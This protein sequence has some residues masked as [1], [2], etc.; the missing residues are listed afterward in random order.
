MRL[1]HKILPNY[2]PFQTNM[3]MDSQPFESMYLLQVASSF[4]HPRLSRLSNGRRFVVSML[5]ASLGGST[6]AWQLLNH[7]RCIRPVVNNGTIS[8]GERGK[9]PY[10]DNTT[11]RDEKDWKMIF[12]I[13]YWI[14]VCI[15]YSFWYLLISSLSHFWQSFIHPWCINF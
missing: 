4:N 5:S 2:T 13:T 9:F 3:T 11:P 8:T 12:D 6:Q 14:Y 15:G 1:L 10:H 7:L